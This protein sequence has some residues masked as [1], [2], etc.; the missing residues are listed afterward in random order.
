M[1]KAAPESA[2][3]DVNRVFGCVVPIAHSVILFLKIEKLFIT[4]SFVT[5]SKSSVSLRLDTPYTI[6]IN[7]ASFPE[8][9]FTLLLH[10]KRVFLSSCL[11]FSYIYERGKFS[12]KR[13]VVLSIVTRL[14]PYIPVPIA[15]PSV[16]F[17]C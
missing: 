11:V 13:R 3:K 12:Q 10:S 15:T 5:D 17:V 2:R 6:V 1:F 4:L 8:S 9:S 16:L 7:I 14:S